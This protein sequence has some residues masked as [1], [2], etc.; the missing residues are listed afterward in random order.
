MLIGAG[1]RAR[2]EGDVTS[3]ILLPGLRWV[4]NISAAPAVSPLLAGG[5]VYLSLKPGIVAAHRV[6]DGQ[7]AWR[8]PLVAD[9]ELAAAPELVFVPASEAVHALKADT[10]REVWLAATGTITAPLLVHAGWLVTVS[11]EMLSA[12][13]AADGAQVWT[14]PAGEVRERPAIDGDVLYVSF[15]DGRVAAFDLATGAPRWERKLR[16]AARPPLVVGDRV[17]VGSSDKRFYALKVQNGEPD[18]KW[19]VGA[20]LLGRAAADDKHVYFTAMDNLV[21]ALDRGSGG[22]RW[23]Q[24]L[25]F[26]PVAGPIVVGEAV[27]VPGS[28]DTL[29][30]FDGR[31]GRAVKQLQLDATLAIPPGAGL[32][33]GESLVT[34]AAIT[35]GLADQ[36]KLWLY[37]PL[38]A[39]PEGPPIEPLSALPGLLVP[40]KT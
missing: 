4:V 7:E 30:F 40:P 28:S 15:A 8:V 24:E 33:P 12:F 21:R 23:R 14:R 35:G 5:Y 26:R 13:R 6:K 16:G 2:A 29:Q 20:E 10:G 38:P 18:W 39:P 11:G 31:T 34:V 22:Q 1:S 25:P 27:L 32:E 17:Y 37:G 3:K 9:Q 19:S 36:W